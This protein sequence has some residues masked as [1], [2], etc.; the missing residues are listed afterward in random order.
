MQGAVAREVIGLQ[1]QV[2]TISG[3]SLNGVQ[4]P[5]EGRVEKRNLLFVQALVCVDKCQYSTHANG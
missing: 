4:E 1:E 2:V 5:M 3:Q